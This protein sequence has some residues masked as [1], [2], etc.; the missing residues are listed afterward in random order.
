MKKI[1]PLN[2]TVK[3]TDGVKEQIV[4]VNRMKKFVFRNTP[5]ETVNNG[6]PS[7]I[8]Q[9]ED[10]VENEETTPEDDNIMVTPETNTTESIKDP[11]EQPK[12]NKHPYSLRRNI[13]K[14]ARYRY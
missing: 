12:E 10:I 1:S 3:Q 9:E 14:P 11:I 2:Y 7:E 6:S 4:H 5:R 8:E 13:K